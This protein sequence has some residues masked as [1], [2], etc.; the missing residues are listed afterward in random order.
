MDRVEKLQ[1]QPPDAIVRFRKWAAIAVGL[2]VLGYLA[3]AL[4]TGLSATALELARFS[5]GLYALVLGL[6]LVNYGLRYIKWHYLLQR[7]DIRVPH[8]TNGWIFLTGLAMAISPA[9]A[10][11]LVKPYLLNACVGASPARTVPALVVERGTDGLAVVILA[12][13]GVSTYYNDATNLIWGTIAAS[14]ALVIA[15]SIRPLAIGVLRAI[16]RIGPLAR[17]ASHLEEVYEATWTCLRPVP[18]AVTMVLSVVAW[19]A[20]CIGYWLVFAGLG[21]AT[22]VGTATFLYAF[23]TV[24]GAP[25]PGGMGMADA[26]LAEGA[27]RLV[28]SITAPQALA[29]SILVRFATLWFGV[30]LGAIGLLRM[31]RMIEDA[32][33]T[34]PRAEGG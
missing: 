12:A 34:I 4:W 9:K 24:F 5:W 8:R 32:K 10:G 23:A 11:E 14:V 2:A 27:T 31:E 28:P 6:T 18:L 22:T 16:G 30:L 25:S 17:T 33:V 20:E 21:V 7:L 29:A 15:I 3:Y 19:F 1:P 26:A 13:V